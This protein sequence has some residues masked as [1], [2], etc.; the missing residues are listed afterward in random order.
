MFW[1][2]R[3]HSLLSG[4]SG[5]FKIVHCDPSKRTKSIT[6]IWKYDR[7]SFRCFTGKVFFPSLGGENPEVK[8]ILK[9]VIKGFLYLEVLSNKKSS[10]PL[11][12]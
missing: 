7:H 10:V 11:N 3:A 4:A 12:N 2:G 9:N 6:F 5:M 8:V 1:L